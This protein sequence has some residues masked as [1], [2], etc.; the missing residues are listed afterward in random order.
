M[1]VVE[2]ASHPDQQHPL[3]TLGSLAVPETN[4]SPHD[5]IPREHNHVPI[6]VI[7]APSAPPVAP[8]AQGLPLLK[9]HQLL[10]LVENGAFISAYSI[11]AGKADHG[12][13]GYL[14]YPLAGVGGGLLGPDKWGC[15]SQKVNEC[16]C[17][18]PFQ[19]LGWGW[20]QLTLVRG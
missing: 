12:I 2:G 11:A 15:R 6:R 5:L 7:L 18:L 20:I 10:A 9:R 14:A 19:M 3:N 16:S 13:G 4:S 17:D 8:I 1:A